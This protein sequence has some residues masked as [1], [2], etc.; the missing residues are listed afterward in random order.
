MVG[1]VAQP[2]KAPAGHAPGLPTGPKKMDEL[3]KRKARSYKRVW[4]PSEAD[5]LGRDPARRWSTAIGHI[6][7]R[8]TR[9]D[10]DRGACRNQCGEITE[11]ALKLTTAILQDLLDTHARL[12]TVATQKEQQARQWDERFQQMPAAWVITDLQGTI[13]DANR[14]AAVLLNVSSDALRGRLLLHFVV[15]RN[16]CAEILRA[17]PVHDAPVDVELTIRPRERAPVRRVRVVVQ[18]ES[19]SNLALWWPTFPNQDQ[20]G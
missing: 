11:E 3:S 5:V 18:G 1:A 7:K 13:L 15:E 20:E 19:A 4:K 6:R 8:L 16:A 2:E 12:Q 14:A 9:L 17:L 10:I